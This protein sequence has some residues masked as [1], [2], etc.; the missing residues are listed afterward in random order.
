MVRDAIY[1]RHRIVVLIRHPDSAESEGDVRGPAAHPD[2]V[3]RTKGCGVDGSDCSG[4]GVEYPDVTS[5]CG[6]FIQ[7][8]GQLCL[9]GDLAHSRIDPR[10]GSTEI[11]DHPHGPVSH[12]NPVARAFQT[13]SCH[14]PRLH[15]HARDP[16]VKRYPNRAE[17]DSGIPGAGY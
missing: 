6:H 8:P 10:E 9:A 16:A 11:V 14:R 3:K 17:P 13:E 15:V 2:W 7:I 4:T 12:R 5:S 1:P